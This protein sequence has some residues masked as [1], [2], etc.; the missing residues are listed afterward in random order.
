MLIWDWKAKVQILLK[1][2]YSISNFTQIYDSK[3]R[4]KIFEMTL[5]YC[6]SFCF[7]PLDRKHKKQCHIGCSCFGTFWCNLKDKNH[8]MEQIE[9]LTWPCIQNR[10]NSFSLRIGKKFTFVSPFGGP[11]IFDEP[12]ISFLSCSVT[13]CQNSVIQIHWTAIGL[14]VDSY[15]WLY[16]EF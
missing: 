2:I 7:R 14:I 3:C 8:E 10:L 5:L 11:W 9:N 13:N 4:K 12:V 6:T 15:L 16:N 1:I